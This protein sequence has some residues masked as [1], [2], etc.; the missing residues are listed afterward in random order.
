MQFLSCPYT[1]TS[2]PKICPKAINGWT[3]SNRRMLLPI[4]SPV[5]HKPTQNTLLTIRTTMP[6][7][8]SELAKYRVKDVIEV[9]RDRKKEITQVFALLTHYDTEMDT[10]SWISIEDF[11]MLDD[12]IIVL[13]SWE[14]AAKLVAEEETALKDHDKETNGIKNSAVNTDDQV[15]N[16]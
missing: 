11:E 12:A 8:L 9:K 14:K 10:S 13:K 16:P 15:N 3:T 5:V 4:F 6:N 1:E 2:S 7:H